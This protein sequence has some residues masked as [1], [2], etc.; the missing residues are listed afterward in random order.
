MLTQ[1][2][3]CFFHVQNYMQHLFSGRISQSETGVNKDSG[4]SDLTVFVWP[5]IQMK[6]AGIKHT[7]HRNDHQ[8]SICLK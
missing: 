4:F 2:H 6:T 5:D 3:L 1:T 7:E 8:K